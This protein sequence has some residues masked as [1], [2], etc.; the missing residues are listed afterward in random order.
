MR[1]HLGVETQRQ[2]SDLPIAR[3]TPALLGLF[4]LVVL[5]MNDLVQSRHIVPQATSWYRK[6]RLTFA[7]AIAAVRRE[8]WHHQASATS[9]A[10]RDVV[11]IPAHIWSRMEAAL[12]H[13]R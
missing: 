4:S 2:W 6:T 9:R 11:E 3:T 8:I 5:W 7:D 12:A 10:D 13:A 1:P